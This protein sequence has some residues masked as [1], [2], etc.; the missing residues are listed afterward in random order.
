M[1]RKMIAKEEA[2]AEALRQQQATDTSNLYTGLTDPQASGQGLGMFRSPEDMRGAMVQNALRSGAIDAKTAIGLVPEKEKIKPS[3]T[4]GQILEDYR[5]GLISESQARELLIRENKAPESRKVQMGTDIVTQQY[6][7][8]TLTWETVGQ[9]PKAFPTNEQAGL[10]T[11]AT[12]KLQDAVHMAKG[13]LA[14]LGGI[15]FNDAERFLTLW[16]RMKG[17]GAR[18]ADLLGSDDPEVESYIAARQDFAGR[19]NQIFFKLRKV[20][21][22]AQAAFI[23]LED[24]KSATI[25]TDMSPA[26]FKA[27]GNVLKQQAMTAMQIAIDL[28]EN[29]IN[30]NE[31]AGLA[32][33]NRRWDQYSLFEKDP[34]DMTPEELTAW[35]A[36]HGE[37]D[38]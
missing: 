12:T 8:E 31:G 16:G 7:P 23:E 19:T 17:T 25:S 3:T 29:G 32:E 6:N 37:P 33:F 4:T 34:K 28:L 26:Q 20:I 18:W 24:L 36:M 14:D 9:G 30:P 13:Q 38:E 2:L 35:M 5:N 11:G 27:A 10:T 21:T 1:G 15:N 22:G